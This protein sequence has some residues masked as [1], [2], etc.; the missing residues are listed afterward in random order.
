MRFIVLLLVIITCYSS[1]SLANDIRPTV[2]LVLSG[3]GAR[4]AAHIGVIEALEEMNVPIDL[5][6]GTS[7]GAVIGGLYASGVP[8]EVIKHDFCELNW[9]SLFKHAIKRKNLYFRRKLDDD[10]FVAK[11]FI[12]MTNR[13]IHFS[14]GLTSGQNL[15][16]IFKSY[17][18][19]LEPL[20]SFGYL[21]IP[22]KAVSTDLL[23]G[24]IVALESGDLALAMLASMAVPGIISPVQ[25][26]DFMLVDGGVSNNLPIQIAKEMGAEVIIVV[27]VTSPLFQKSQIHDLT[28]VLGQLS[29]ILTNNNIRESESQLTTEDIVI[30][31][32]LR[33]IS[34]TNFDRFKDAIEPGKIAAYEMQDR[35][36]PLAEK[37]YVPLSSV[38]YIIAPLRILN[39]SVYTNHAFCRKTYSDYLRL[40]SDLV[41]VY[42]I[43]HHI[44]KLYG[45]NIFDKVYYGIQTENGY[46][47]LEVMPHLK[48]KRTF[49]FQESLL[50]QSDFRDDSQFSFV[51]GITNPRVNQ[52][53]GEWRVI[54]AVG[55]NLGFLA[56]IYQPIEPSLSLYINPYLYFNR[57]P[58]FIFYNF[59]EVARF[60]DNTYV[61]GLNIG[62]NFSNWGRLYGFFNLNYQ[63]YELI[64]SNPPLTSGFERQYITGGTVEWD[65]LDNL[66]FPH[67]GFKGEASLYS[68]RAYF[69]QDP[70]YSQFTYKSLAACST[71]K[72]TWVLHARY[73]HTLS[74]EPNFISQFTLGGLFQLTGLQDEELMGQNAILGSLIYF[75][76]LKKIEFIPNRPFPI[77]IGGSFEAG[78]VWGDSNLP[79]PHSP[80][81]VNSLFIGTNTIIGPVYLG[82]GLTYNGRRA[83]HLLIGPFF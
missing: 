5:I 73:D 12:G 4:G 11:N 25:V 42:D 17:T 33:N 75:Y 68:S 66:Y 44:D 55:T 32:K 20:P 78:N 2:G 72:H 28:T 70:H 83:V 23:T 30:I 37:N 14:Y 45:L 65:L 16:E 10:I 8:I 62:Y 69:T 52:L 67:H 63:D 21:P 40:E 71:G 1:L 80:V 38:P 81:Y 13:K 48:P 76:E 31:P 26:N 3:G 41:T 7:M 24:Q 9:Q 51:L 22:F 74:G 49:L 6:V 58:L 29:N 47:E 61:A 34:T 53:L 82:G 59:E 39:V 54:G 15:Y 64:V 77:Y 35:L 79:S 43:N 50:L 36:L 19:E 18:I 27:N 57:E 60:V 46:P 56:E